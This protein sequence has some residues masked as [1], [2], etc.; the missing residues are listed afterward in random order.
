MPASG[1]SSH[2]HVI[3]LQMAVTVLRVNECMPCHSQLL[4]PLTFEKKEAS[5]LTCSTQSTSPAA[6]RGRQGW[7]NTMH[8]VNVI[9]CSW[10]M[11]LM[12]VAWRHG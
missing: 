3:S 12:M 5:S 2:P 4:P 10:N 6:G 7:C 9:A 11:Q 8:A 1:S